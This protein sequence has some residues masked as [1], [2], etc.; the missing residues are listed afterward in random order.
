MNS[1][2]IHTDGAHR[3]T[4]EEVVS[5]PVPAKTRSYQP[6]SHEKFIN[7]IHAMAGDFGLELG[8]P[9]YGVSAPD[10]ETRFCQRLFGT[11]DVIGQDH[12]DNQV[13]LMIGF[14]NS[15]DKSLA[16]GVCFG[17]RVFVCDNLVFTGMAGENGIKGAAFH[18]HTV[19]VHPVFTERLKL[20]MSQFEVFRNFQEKF[21]GRLQETRVDQDRAYAT[22]VRAVK[23][24]ALPNKDVI[25]VADEWDYQAEV[26][27][28]DI[29]RPWYKD[30]QER[31]AWSLLNAFTEEA[32]KDQE[33]NI[34]T[35]SNRSFRLSSFFHDEFASNHSIVL[36]N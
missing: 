25:R 3:A 11:F 17:S 5:I 29:D 16:A 21:Y 27:D 14:R 20:A 34:V 13:R 9:Q 23:A 10:K 28:G 6:V 32:K 12:M 2:A 30:F 31:N 18:R 1:L 36:A 15:Y 35:A 19:N 24:D 22:I 33:K 7:L 26:P 4:K 8:N